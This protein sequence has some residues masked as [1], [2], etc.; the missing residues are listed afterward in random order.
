MGYKTEDEAIAAAK[1]DVSGFI[2]FDGHN[3]DEYLDNGCLGWDGKSHRCDCGNRR[4]YWAII[5]HDD[6]TFSAYAEAY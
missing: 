2:T 4:V 3:C 5:Q 1:E 6:G